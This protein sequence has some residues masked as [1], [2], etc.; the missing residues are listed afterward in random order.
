VPDI[1]CARRLHDAGVG[2]YG[3]L[4]RASRGAYYIYENISKTGLSAERFCEILLAEGH[5]MMFPGMLFGDDT[6]SYVR[7]SLVQPLDLIEEAAAKM[8]E[9]ISKHRATG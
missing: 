6:H 1:C 5:V 9:V 8:E 4:L 2:S 7:I 3:S